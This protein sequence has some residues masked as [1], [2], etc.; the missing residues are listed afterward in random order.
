[1]QLFYSTNS[2]YA[3][4]CRIVTLEKGLQNRIEFINV[5]PLENPPQLR[6]VNPLG[7]VPALVTDD[8]LH[9]CE[10]P[11]ICEYLDMLAPSPMFY[12]KDDARICALAMAALADGI[13][14]AAVACVLENRKSQKSPEWVERK[15][16]AAMRAIA[17]FAGAS[18]QH[19]P[20]SI[21]TVNLAVAL[22]YVSFRLPHLNWRGEHPALAGWLEKMNKRPSFEATKPQA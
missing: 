1:M 3:R 5:N 8:G 6:A 9:L 22:A 4:K 21:G 17:K 13:M 10:S 20:L 15:E 16:E 12:P 2:P 14:D 11:V 18:M 7:T 19:A